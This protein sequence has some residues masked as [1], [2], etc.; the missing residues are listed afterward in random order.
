M[1]RAKKIDRNQPEIVQLF[2]DLGAMVSV[3]SA[4]GGGFT[5][6]VVQFRRP[7]NGH[8]VTLLVEIKDGELSP[9]RQALTPL[10]IVFHTAWNCHIVNCEQDVYDLMEMNNPDGKYAE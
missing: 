9:S 7:C 1:S 6:L 8:I 5:D 10:Q 2:R 3:T 4:V